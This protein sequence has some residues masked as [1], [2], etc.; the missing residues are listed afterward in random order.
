MLASTELDARQAVTP[1]A[2]GPHQLVSVPPVVPPMGVLNHATVAAF[3]EFW[4]RKA[5]D[6]PNR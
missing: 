5:P 3:N 2:Y 4:F 1:L 6:A